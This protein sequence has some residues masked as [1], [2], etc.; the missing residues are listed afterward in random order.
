MQHLRFIP[1]KSNS[2][3][4]SYES[5]VF[6]SAVTRFAVFHSFCRY[7]DSIA[8]NKSF[9]RQTMTEWCS[10]NSI[11]E[12]TECECCFNLPLFS[13]TLSN[14]QQERLQVLGKHC[15]QIPRVDIEISWSGLSLFAHL[16]P[17][18]VTAWKANRQY[19]CKPSLLFAWSN[20]TGC[21]K[22]RNALHNI[23]SYN[24][25]SSNVLITSR[26]M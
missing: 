2:Q 11:S 22:F 21:D 5:P 19:N 24:G 10:R 12:K 25:R 18:F 7:S 13:T 17:Y 15:L 14:L 3:L 23:D 26:C 6:L 1:R 20:T 4:K 9:L 8:K 16:S